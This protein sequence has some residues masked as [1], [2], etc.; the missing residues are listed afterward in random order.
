MEK[1][2]FKI[3]IEAPREKVWDVLWNSD[4]YPKWT[5]VFSEGSRAE[6]DWKK[7]S[8]VLF[9]DGKGDG[10][11]STIAENIPN[12]Y[13][14]IKHKGMIKNGKEDFDSDE[15]K[16]WAGAEENY[17]LKAMGNKT[18]LKV[19]IDI[20][21]EYKDYFEKTFPKALDKVKELAEQNLN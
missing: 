16:S 15:V 5:S 11:I 6:T 18:E 4:T 3:S 2:E 20:A 1:Q 21:D 17:T 8:R 13:M 7:G 10:M 14:S 9:T 12:S 19:D